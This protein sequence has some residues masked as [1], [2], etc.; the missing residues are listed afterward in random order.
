MKKK[1]AFI[2]PMLA[3]Y[4][5]TFYEKLFN[6]A[7][8]EWC[9]FHGIKKVE[10]GRP[11]Y[12]ESILFQNVP[13]NFNSFKLGPLEFYY[14]FGLN[15]KVREFKP[16]III[17][18]GNLSVIS[19]I[20]LMKWAKKRKLKVILWI[21]SWE[22]EKIKSLVKH[23]KILACKYYYFKADQFIAYG[24]HAKRLL[25]DLGIMKYKI[26]IAFNGIET[27]LMQKNKTRILKEVNNVRI[28]Y[29]N[30]D[31]LIFVYVGGLI[32]SKKVIQLIE[33][34]DNLNKKYRSI[35]LWIIG[36][37]AL[38]TKVQLLIKQLSNRN[39]IYFGR[40]LTDVDLF[41]AAS[42][43]FVL[44]GSGGVALTQALFWMKPCICSVADGTEED[45]IIDGETGFYFQRN[46]WT[47]FQAAMEK[48]IKTGIQKRKRMGQN[49]H[50]LI[51]NRSNVNKMVEVFKDTIN[52]A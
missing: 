11:H 32:E 37:G 18:Y 7:N 44:P 15:R 20:L 5:V 52:N 24:T 35:K 13:Y 48:F 25:V 4:R 50:N 17:M 26:K 22:R 28:K 21:C 33:Q 31:D 6:D 19:N 36:D 27:D 1:I 41:F 46:N 43:C 51:I 42:D 8:N 29:A 16:N 3:P 40:I 34:F 38:R 30:P 45:L 9:L 14:H 10:D 12:K 23:L 39:I 2:V 47:D 49:G